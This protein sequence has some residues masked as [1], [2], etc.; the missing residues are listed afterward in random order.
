[1]ADA[2]IRFDNADDYELFMSRWSHLAGEMFLDWVQPAP[3]LRWLDVGCGSGLSGEALTEEGHIWVGCDISAAMLD[4]AV[5]REVCVGVRVCCRPAS[6]CVC[7]SNRAAGRGMGGHTLRL[8]PPCAGGAA[9]A[10]ARK[11]KLHG[12]TRVQH[13][14]P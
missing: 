6:A 4:V 5:E 10:N 7:G 13:H 1:M 14:P 11:C 2:P 3:G 9:R 8:L 12:A